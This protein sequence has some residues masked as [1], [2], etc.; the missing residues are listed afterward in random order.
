MRAD[1]RKSTHQADRL[2]T[3]FP[4]SKRKTEKLLYS[5]T[6]TTAGSY[7]NAESNIMLEFSYKLRG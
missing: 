1:G 7:L 3:N 6:N 5:H 2:Y 4:L